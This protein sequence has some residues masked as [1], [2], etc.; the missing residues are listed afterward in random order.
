MMMSRLARG[1]TGALFVVTSLAAG[2]RLL[3]A[4]ELTSHV[5]IVD[6]QLSALVDRGARRSATFRNLLTTIESN[7]LIVLV[8]CQAPAEPAT[9]AAGRPQS[10]SPRP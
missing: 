3:E 1:L 10:T 5:R 7:R 2:A 9:S 4:Q 6:E 8:R